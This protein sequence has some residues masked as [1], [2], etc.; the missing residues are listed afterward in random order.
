MVGLRM[1]KGSENY[2][3]EM[4]ESC[5]CQVYQSCTLYISFPL[6]SMHNF[7]SMQISTHWKL[8]AYLP[9]SLN[10]FSDT[11]NGS[12]LLNREQNNAILF[13]EV[14]ESNFVQED[15]VTKLSRIQ[16]IAFIWNHTGIKK[17]QHFV[18][19][20]TSIE[21]FLANSQLSK[22]TSCFECYYEFWV[23]KVSASV[24]V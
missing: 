6:A 17:R 4:D 12:S 7:P 5:T 9:R 2:S 18:A 15:K 16:T 20:V 19:R 23:T 10:T 24:L 8:W 13:A 21:I 11:E 3:F 1:F 22:Q 14:W